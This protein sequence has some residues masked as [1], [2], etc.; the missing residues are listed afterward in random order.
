MG[1][2]TT[3]DVEVM[4]PTKCLARFVYGCVV[5]CVELFEE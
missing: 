5:L 4:V 1:G 2:I 3:R